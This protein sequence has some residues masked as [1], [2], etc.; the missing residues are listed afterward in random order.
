MSELLKGHLGFKGKSAYE[1]W[2]EEGHE[3][4]KADFLESLTDNSLVKLEKEE[5]QIAHNNLQNQI[6]SLASGSPLV[7]SNISEMT[8]TSK[9]YVN[10]S[11][12]HWYWYN[13]TSWQDGGVYQATED[14]ETINKLEE[15]LCVVE[16]IVGGNVKISQSSYIDKSYVVND[17]FVYPVD[18]TTYYSTNPI[19]ISSFKIGST[20]KLKASI[21]GNNGAFLCDSNMYALDYINGNNAEEKGYTPS[22]SPQDITFTMVKNAKFI[23]ANIRNSLYTDSSIFN[24]YGVVDNLDKIT[25]FVNKKMKNSIYKNIVIGKNILNPL[26]MIPGFLNESGII[27]KSDSYST[28]DFIYLKKDESIV[29]SP[30]I[31]K[32]CSYNQNKIAITDSFIDDTISNFTYTSPNDC[33]IRATLFNSDSKKQIE[34]GTTP[35]SYQA[36]YTETSCEEGVHLSNTQLQDVG[37][38]LKGKKWIPCG[39]SFT[40]YTNKTFK[41]GQFMNKGMTYPRLIA[42]RTGIN[43]NETFFSSGRT[44]AYPSDGTFTNSL[45][46]PSANCYYKNIPEDADYI[47]IMLG[48]NDVNH[49]SGMG[50]TPDGEDATGVIKLGTINDTDTSTYY[51]A[52]N[53]VL[54]WLRENRPFAHVGIIVTNGTGKQDF[55]EAQINLAKKYGYPYI[56]LNG[57][58]RT[59][60]MIR[61]YNPNISTTLKDILRKTQAVD[62]NGSVTGSI[63]IHPNYLTHEYESYFIESWLRSL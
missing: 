8:D 2:L 51:G 56:N 37:N 40:D 6:N 15:N 28:S 55:T 5:R 34:Y 22:P 60:A 30:R 47:T 63:N 57:D 21:N 23:V 36:F 18:S 32:F 59:P 25:D 33:Y 19:D 26:T 27:T 24:V 52:Y 13:G 46:C 45:T 10:T 20:I 31:R 48:I 1:I 54:S 49:Q 4:T 62:Y 61:C 12:G 11:N 9:V 44:M 29:I 7:A 53:S 41:N 58:E 50:S 42:E 17:N 38:I 3:G 43:I 35:S 14:S 39:D 16:D